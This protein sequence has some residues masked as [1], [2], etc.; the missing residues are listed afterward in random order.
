MLTIEAIM[1]L[2]TQYG[3]FL[4]LPVSILEGPVVAM[5]AGAL[6]SFHVLNGLLVYAY[7][8]G[9]IELNEFRE[10]GVVP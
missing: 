9:S 6:V 1:A 10:S 3:Y 7:A 5:L 8:G 2:L 4:L